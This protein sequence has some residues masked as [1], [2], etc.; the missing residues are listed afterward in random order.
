MLEHKKYWGE[1]TDLAIE[2]FDIG[3]ESMPAEIIVAFAAIKKCAAIANAKLGKLDKKKRDVI[4]EAADAILRGELENQFP[5]HVWQTGSGTGTNMNINEVI[6]GYGNE[7]AGE[8]LLHPNDDVNMSQSS[9]DTFPSA[10]HIAAVVSMRTRLIPEI[11]ALIDSFKKIEKENKKIIK[12]GRTHLQDAT[13]IRFSQE[14]SGWKS[15]LEVSLKLL[16]SALEPLRCLAEG[17][18]AVGTGINCPEGFRELFLLE[19]SAELGERFKAPANNFHAMTARDEL[20]FAHGALKALASDLMKIANDVRFLAS[21]PRCGY[22]EITIPFNEKGSSIMPGKVNPT[23]CEQ[24]TMV[25]LQVM[26]NDTVMAFANSQG[27]FELNVYAPV[28]AYNF[29]Q[30]VNLLV[31]SI[32][33]FNEYCVKGI[34]ANGAKMQDN[35]QKSLMLVTALSPAI[36]YDAAGQVA[37][38]ALESGKTLKEVCL[39]KKLM[40]EET[41]DT[42]TNPEKLV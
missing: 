4:C 32:H 9:N 10:M 24:V 26:A 11:E 23:Q 18:T 8:T 40:D 28:I 1:Q 41:F 12:I 38:E 14:V 13:P 34:K 42:L 30:S 39:E 21:G 31:D 20:V 15:M 22:G 2:H 7:I 6:A 3:D 16:K 35:L 37:K 5:L 25:A 29:L 33:C 17:G 27:N 36:G 19:L